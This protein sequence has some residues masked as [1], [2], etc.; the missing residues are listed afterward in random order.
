MT[1]APGKGSTFWFTALLDVAPT[2]DAS[3]TLAMET[4]SLAGKL[5]LLV[6]DTAL[7]LRILDK[8]LKRW[9]MQTVLFE[10]AAP[11]LVWLADHEADIILTDMHMPD[12][13]G[14]Q[15]AETLKA[16][17]PTALVVLL[18]SGVMR[19]GEAARVFDARL[20]KPYR[21]S[22]LFNALS[23]LTLPASGTPATAPALQSA[24][25]SKQKRILVADDNAIN[26]KVA[27]AMLAKL[28]YNAVTAINGREAADAVSLSLSQ[29]DP[30][31]PFAAVLMD[32]NM[33][34][35]DGLEATQ[36]ILATH[37]TAAPPMIA[38]TA[39]VLE[40][41]RQ[42]CLNAGMIGFLAK[43]LR[44]DEL[45]EALER[46]CTDDGATQPDHSVA[47]IES[48]AAGAHIQGAKGSNDPQNQ[49][50]LMDW[51]RLEQFKAFDDDS[52]S[53]TRDVV[54]LFVQDA[55]N[56]NT[57]LAA[58]LQDANSCLISCVAGMLAREQ[59]LALLYG[60]CWRFKAEK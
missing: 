36:L 35:M 14:Q 5:A 13:D 60:R 29:W 51:S 7:N 40:E 54:A 53:M 50:V 27:L 28:G 46:Y 37:G 45:A 30:Q 44:L 33:P 59:K 17:L 10:R 12:M 18:T 56:H 58:A 16:K 8:Q 38:L 22:Q 3:Q 42:R 20:L 55:P 11:A 43:P 41:D 48:E 32:A 47:A 34:V 1:S 9:G 15:F 52:L 24:V 19:T 23:R 2:P 21:Q 57:A 39:S 4:A 49:A 26:L 6:D 25:V 31:G